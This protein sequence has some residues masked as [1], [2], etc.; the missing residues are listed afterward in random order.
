MTRSHIARLLALGLAAAAAITAG[1]GA[2][3]ASH[4]VSASTASTVPAADS[5]DVDAREGDWSWP[6]APPHPVT[7]PFEVTGPYSPGHR[8]I[9]LGVQPAAA[10][11][12]PASGV[13]R[14][15]G[16]VVDRPVLSI[17]HDDGTISSFEPVEATVAIGERVERG[18]IV[19]HLS[20]SIRHAPQGGL[21]LGAR[22][23]GAYLNP[24]FLLGALAPAVLLPLGDRTDAGRVALEVGRPAGFHA[25]S[26]HSRR[27]QTT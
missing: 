18:Q 19:G 25:R 16:V 27:P 20:S 14:F 5:I 10:V 2:G 4:P 12:A 13:V 8:G 24:L 6:V 26:Q 3:P 11:A 7:R 15:A 9:D 22:V 23:D 17:A 1:V 21:H